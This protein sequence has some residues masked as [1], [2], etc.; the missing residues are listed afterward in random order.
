[1]KVIAYSVMVL[2][3]AT[4]HSLASDQVV[5]RPLC[6]RY[7]LC[8]LGSFLDEDASPNI[9]DRLLPDATA[10]FSVAE[11]EAAAQEAGLRTLLLRWEA[12]AAADFNRPCVLYIRS[13]LQAPSPD[14]FVACFG[15]RGTE[16]CLADYPRRPVWV[17]REKLLSVWSGIVLYVDRADGEALAGLYRQTW[18][19]KARIIFGVTLTL[20]AALLGWR[21]W[22]EFHRARLPE[23]KPAASVQAPLP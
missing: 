13:S 1:M 19:T 22:K 10:P 8:L 21:V 4:S 6:G 16:V 20:F 3:L 9:W 17:S 5:Q 7:A 12:P 2:F 18:L 14:H 11:L 15:S 23:A